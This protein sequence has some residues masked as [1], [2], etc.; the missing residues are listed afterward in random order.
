MLQPNA[1]LASKGDLLPRSLDVSLSEEFKN[2]LN[3]ISQQRNLC[4]L[5]GI[6]SEVGG[7]TSI[8]FFF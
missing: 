4:L 7:N 1:F 5:T 8:F 2:S 6:S 3:S